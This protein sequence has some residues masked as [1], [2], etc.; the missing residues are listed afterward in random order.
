M[1]KTQSSCLLVSN[2]PVYSKWM[3]VFGCFVILALTWFAYWPI[4]ECGFIWD[5]D[6]YVTQNMTLRDVAG[7]KRIWLEP[8]AVPQYYPMVHTTFWCEYHL[9]ELNPLGYHL[10]NVSLHLLVALLWWRVLSSMGMSHAYLAALLFAIH[11][12]HVES[13]A[14]ITERKNI[15]SGVFYLLAAWNYWHF[16]TLEKNSGYKRWSW[17]GLALLCFVCALLSKSVTATLPAALI[18]VLW[19]HRGRFPYKDLLFLVPFFLVGIVS[20]LYTAHLEESLV[21]AHGQEF[22]QSIVERTLLAGSIVWAYIGKLLWP[23]ELIF[24]YPRWRILPFEIMSW[25][26]VV[27]ILF[28]AWM[29]LKN[30]KVWGGQFQVCWFYFIGTLFPALGFFNVFPM[31][32]SWI[33]DHFQYLASMGILVFIAMGLGKIKHHCPRVGLLLIVLIIGGLT[34]RTRA[35]VPVYQNTQTL[36]EHVV[37]HNSSSWAA[38]NNLGTLYANAGHQAKALSLF[39]QSLVLNRQQTKANENMG[40]YYYK[41]QQW[42]LAA[43]YYQTCLQREP[44][45][46]SIRLKLVTTLR[47]GGKRQ[48]ALKQA[49]QCVKRHPQFAQAW[50]ESAMLFEQLNRP[51]KAIKAWQRAIKIQPEKAYWHYQLGVVA[52]QAN[53]VQRAIDAQQKASQLAPSMAAPYSQLA[54]LAVMQSKW[55]QALTLIDH[56]RKLEPDNQAVTQRL[57]WLYS[58]IEQA[59]QSHKAL[60]LKLTLQQIPDEIKQ[61]Q[62]LNMVQTYAAAFAANKK[63]E[64]AIQW[65]TH[66]QTLSP[67]LDLADTESALVRQRLNLY[68]NQQSYTQP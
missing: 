64:Q 22:N 27:S 45:N 44:G 8:G 20:G 42:Q 41:Q 25:L 5:D 12:V 23:A 17:Y 38:K 67:E 14:W 47:R 50:V 2:S 34:F 29:F 3:I 30:R 43:F 31:K 54:Q 9:W 4:T 36:W 19:Y 32:F 62:D 49:A 24:F 21:G 13:V 48:Q 40:S 59:D 65:Q 56:A 11:P 58:T 26:T 39:R 33:A 10:V 63:F 60:A 28:V 57:I 35:Q 16:F 68:L 55:G 6:A 52:M 53:Q 7:L 18:L 15:L 1:S 37:A 51:G 61:C 66:A 46:V